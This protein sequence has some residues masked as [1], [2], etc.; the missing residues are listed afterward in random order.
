MSAQEFRRMEQE[1]PAVAER[2]RAAVRARL[3]D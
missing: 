1:L 3:S 2:V